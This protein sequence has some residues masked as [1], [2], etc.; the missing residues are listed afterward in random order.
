V[1]VTPVFASSTRAGPTFEELLDEDELDDEPHAAAPRAAT[2][3]SA[4]NALGFI[5]T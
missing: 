1:N 5:Y 4:T 3:A 2:A